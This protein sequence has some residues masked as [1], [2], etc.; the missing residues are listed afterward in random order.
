MTSLTSHRRRR[1]HP[2]AVLPGLIVVGAI[3]TIV[4]PLLWMVLIAFQQPRA[5]I[6]PGWRFEFSLHNFAEVFNPNTVFGSQVLNSL[7]IVVAATGLTLVIATFASY[8]L[9]QLQWSRR[10]VLGVLS[11]AALL[12]VIPPM[13]LVPGLYATLTNIGLV[14]TLGGLILV[15]TVFNLP[16]ALIMTKFSFD[17]LP[18]ELKESASVD[19]TSEF[20]VFRRIMLPLAMP[21]ISAVGIFTAIQVWN[22]FLFGLVFTSGGRTA[23][24]TVGIAALIQP[25]E[26]RFG[27]MAAI[28]V[29][30]AIPIIILAIAANRQIVS[31]LV[32]GAV[33]G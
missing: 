12:Q 29:V 32:G 5:I 8:S 28:G 21:G 22:E 20:G 23:P 1:R 3:V 11:G 6:A 9:S 18:V 17:A 19:G 7:I 31:G 13:T 10:V 33:K 24:I 26:I 15:N 14:N 16:F 25:Q 2:T 27:G 30:T 4:V